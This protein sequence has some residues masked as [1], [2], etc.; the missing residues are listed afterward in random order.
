MFYLPGEYLMNPRIPATGCYTTG[1][2]QEFTGLPMSISLRFA[3]DLKSPTGPW[4]DPKLI[5]GKRHHLTFRDL[6]EVRHI[7]ALRQAGITIREIRRLAGRSPLV[8]YPFSKLG[9]RENSKERGDLFES[10]DHQ[11]NRPVSWYPGLEWGLEEIGR[12]VV[13]DPGRNWGAPTMAESGMKT[14]TLRDSHTAQGEDADAVAEEY[15][16]TPGEVLAAVSFELELDRRRSARRH[17]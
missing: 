16:T 7:Q 9:S 8:R 5:M 12:A 11:D 10:V 14:R 4:N 6:I 13:L 1:E 17:T 15:Q 2:V 3:R